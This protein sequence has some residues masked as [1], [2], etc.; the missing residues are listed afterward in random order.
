MPL[1]PS[2]NFSPLMTPAQRMETG[3]RCAGAFRLNDVQPTT[4]RWLWPGRIPLGYITLL[5]GDPGAGKSLV[6]LDIAARVSRGAPWPDVNDETGMTNDETSDHSSFDIRHSSFSPNLQP[7]RNS[8]AAA[9]NPNSPLPAP[10]SVIVLTV[11]DHF[12]NTV[13]PRL[14]ALGAQAV[15]KRQDRC[16]RWEWKLPD[17]GAQNHGGEFC[18]PMSM[19][20]TPD[21]TTLPLPVPSP[22][23]PV[24]LPALTPVRSSPFSTEWSQCE[25]RDAAKNY[26]V[27]SNRF[28]HGRDCGPESSGIRLSPYAICLL[29]FPHPIHGANKRRSRS[30]QA[31]V[32]RACQRVDDPRK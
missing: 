27:Q 26:Q 3:I 11:E 7:E 2:N 28:R 6:A 4:L 20:T 8:S 29:V 1:I 31:V 15:F 13:R 14:E 32:R 12:A 23:P 19:N 9:D 30:Y 10:A 25:C 18:A 17:Q 5:V 21:S 22:W 16:I 24:S